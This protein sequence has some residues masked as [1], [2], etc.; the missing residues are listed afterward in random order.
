MFNRP[1]FYDTSTDQVD[2]VKSFLKSSII[3]V[4]QQLVEN[5]G[6]ENEKA[7][8]GSTNIAVYMQA[9]INM[10]RKKQKSYLKSEIEKLSTNIDKE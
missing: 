1:I 6:D 3:K 9:G 10:E 2:R 4:L 7:E 5:I 8:Q